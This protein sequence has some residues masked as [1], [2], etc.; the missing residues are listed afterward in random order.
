MDRD[1]NA[2]YTYITKRVH[3]SDFDV[4]KKRSLR[5]KAKQYNVDNGELADDE[6][7]LELEPIQ[8]ASRLLAIKAASA[9]IAYRHGAI[10]YFDN[11]LYYASFIKLA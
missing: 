5:R 9:Y 1:Y 2:L 11:K 3:P 6:A 10:R 8:P 7:G 4:Y